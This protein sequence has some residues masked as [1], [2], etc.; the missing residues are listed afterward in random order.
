MAT[1]PPYL[2]RYGYSAT[3]AENWQMP[4]TA[5]SAAEVAAERGWPQLTIQV[6]GHSEVDGHTWYTIGCSLTLSGAGRMNWSVLRRLSQLR[7]ALHSEVKVMLGRD[8]EKHFTDAP[9]AKKGGLPGTTARLNT[10]CGALATCINTGSAPPTVVANSL[11][12]FE[13][14]VPDDEDL[15]L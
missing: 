14:P 7:E 1:V 5:E 15:S 6:S 13:A 11:R 12:F 10:W 9:F 2:E 3:S 4:P 8:Y